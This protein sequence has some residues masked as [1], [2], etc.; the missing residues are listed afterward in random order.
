MVTRSQIGTLRSVQRYGSSTTHFVVSPIPANYQSA[1]A[2]PQRRVAM[3]DEHK[4]LIDNKTWCLVPRPPSAN[5]V[6]SK[7]ILKHKFHSNGSLARHK[8]RWVVHGFS[9]RHNIDYDETFSPVIKHAT[10]TCHPQHCCPTLLA[11]PPP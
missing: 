11:D 7:W 9:Q 8:V 6:T 1:L 4:A 2:N 5:I 10:D 3:A